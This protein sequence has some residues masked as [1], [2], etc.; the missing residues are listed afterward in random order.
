MK[1]TKVLGSVL[2]VLPKSTGD[3]LCKKIVKNY[4]DKYAEIE[5]EGMENLQG[6]RGPVVFIPNHLSNSDG[7]ILNRVLKEFDPTFV[8]G[9]K[10]KGDS[11]TNIGMRV[12]KSIN[13]KPNSADKEALSK[14]IK[15]LKDGGNIVIF[16]E[17]TRSRVGSMIEGKKG[18]VLIAKMSKATIVPVG[19][20]GSENLLPIN[21]EGNMGEEN[22]QNAKVWVNI[23]K[24]VALPEKIKEEEKHAYEERALKTLMGAIAALLPEEYRGVYK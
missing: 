16:P 3:S 12:I 10:L 13:I 23:G 14:T 4:L 9:V 5:V 11:F 7:L 8:A 22:F 20:H 24:P 15:T 19:I 2:K 21:K 6:L 17:G 18:I 1:K